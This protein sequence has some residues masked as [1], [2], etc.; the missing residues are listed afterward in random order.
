MLILF[1]IDATLLTSSKAGILALE[2]GGREVLR[3]RLQVVHAGG[4]QHRPRHLAVT[5]KL[6]RRRFREQPVNARGG[7]RSG[8]TN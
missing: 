7:R 5:R 6:E 2:Q 1:D 3:F 8:R 4:V